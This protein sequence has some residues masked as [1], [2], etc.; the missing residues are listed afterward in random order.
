MRDF[1]RSTGSPAGGEGLALLLGG[2]GEGG[3]GGDRGRGGSSPAPAT[4]RGMRF[5]AT[6]GAAAAGRWD[7]A[8]VLRHAL[9]LPGNPTGGDGG[10]G[11]PPALLDAAGEVDF[12][13]LMAQVDGKLAG[14][15][16]APAEDDAGEGKIGTKVIPAFPLRPAL[17]G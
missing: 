11:A 4:G 8:D 13:A 7:S 2:D 10:G 12:T 5:A 6:S 15:S 1:G 9:D 16:V 3:E 17:G 14:L